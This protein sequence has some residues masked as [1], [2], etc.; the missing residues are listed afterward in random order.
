MLRLTK[1]LFLDKPDA[2]YMDYFERV[3][4]NHILSSQHPTKGGF[5]YFTPIRPRHYRVYSQPQEGFWCCVG[6]GLENHG[7]YGEMIY[8]K[9]DND[10]YINLFM[11][12]ELNWKEKGLVI[13][14]TTQFPNEEQ[15]DLVLKLKK[16]DQFTIWIRYPKWVK[17]NSF[18]I[19]INGKLITINAQPS[20]YIPIKRNWK[21][22]DK[23]TL[24][25]PMETT[26]ETLPDGSPWVS[27]LHGPI[28]LA[29]KTDTSDLRG[30][31][32]NSTR[33]GHVAPG[34]LYPMDESPILVSNTSGDYLSTVKPIPGKPM[35]FSIGT[36]VYPK[37]YE[38]L[39][40]VPFYQLHDARYMLYWPVMSSAE[41]ETKI[42]SIKAKEQVKLALEQQTDDYIALGEQ[43]PEADH[44]FQGNKSNAGED[45]SVFWRSTADW[46]SYDLK[47]TSLLAKRLRLTYGTDKRLR[48]FDIFINNQ[49]IKSERMET[50]SIKGIHEAD[51]EL[52]NELIGKPL[53]TIKIVAKNGTNTGAIYSIRLLK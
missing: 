27:F 53:L 19:E 46:I 42:S 40:L 35:N 45:A 12:S 34:K 13:I 48:E 22:G 17:Q 31:F 1:S 3:L 51:Y 8:A 26:V 33:M 49:L 41:L 16:P 10:L 36:S 50:G 6:T 43:Q 20:S 15:S 25:F 29:A 47:N 32:A 5:V 37:K 30:L 44:N 24:H 28:V 39:T 7:K 11:S 2:N 18:K 52:P 21:S 9:S 38:S 23:I 4:F 14:Q